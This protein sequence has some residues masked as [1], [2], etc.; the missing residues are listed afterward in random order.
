MMVMCVV[1]V[2]VPDTLLLVLWFVLDAPFPET[3]DIDGSDHY[4]CR[5]NL[6]FIAFFLAYH[7][8][9]SVGVSAIAFI[10]RRLPSFFG[11]LVQVSLS[12]YT[13]TLLMCVFVPVLA[14]VNHFGRYVFGNVFVA[15]VFFS[16]VAIN[17]LPK[18]WL[19]LARGPTTIDPSGCRP[20]SRPV[21]SPNSIT[22][23]SPSMLPMHYDKDLSLRASV[24]T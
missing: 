19:R 13:M 9:L 17:V 24:A 11:E 22:E 21:T 8:V 18:L 14:V 7:F 12:V 15:A 20:T 1:G 4:F 23:A 5:Y 10:T 16:A 2:L 3:I 6:I